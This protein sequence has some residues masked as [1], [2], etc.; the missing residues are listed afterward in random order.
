[1]L[2][3]ARAQPS[4]KLRRIGYLS[5]RSGPIPIDAEFAAGMRDL[6]YFEGRD[7]VIEYRWAAGDDVRLKAMATALVQQKVDVIV[8]AST[9][10]IQAARDATKTIP[11]VMSAAADPVATGLVSSL[12]R[13]GGNVTGLSLLTNDLA[14]KALE[15]ATALL[16]G[17]KRIALLAVGPTPATKLLIQA[18]EDAGHRKGIRVFPHMVVRPDQIAPA[19]DA[20]RREG[21]QFLV[22]QSAPFTAEHRASILSLAGQAKLPTVSDARLFADEGGLA[23]YGPSFADMY[24]RAATYVDKILRGAK[25]GALPIEQPLKFELVINLRT[26]QALGVDVPQVLLQRADEVIR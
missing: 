23:A 11:I 24:R 9:P 13:P 25:P 7:L 16:P 4:T 1:V 17:T 10:V 20:M 2:D 3:G 15:L 5:L 6:G 22:I 19:F 26:A 12:S 18:L 14:G 21:A 8:A